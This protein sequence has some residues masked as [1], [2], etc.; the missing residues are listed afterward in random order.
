MATLAVIITGRNLCL[1]PSTTASATLKPPSLSCLINETSTTP[2]RTAIPH[3]L[4]NPLLPVPTNTHLKP[5]N[6]R[7]RRLKPEVEPR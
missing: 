2:F 5:V 4:M 7:Y 1:Q 6:R 3:K